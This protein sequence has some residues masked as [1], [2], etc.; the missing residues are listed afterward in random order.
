M[1]NLV[2]V[3]LQGILNI[4]TSVLDVLLYPINLLFAN[5]FPD[6]TDALFIFTGFLNNYVGSNL[7]WFFS[8]LPPNFRSLLILWFTFVIAYYSIYYT[9]R[10]SIRVF[11][12]IQKLKFW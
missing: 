7:A 3:L 9:Y 12:L 11:S 5:I 10:I 1:D 4:I 6:M 8:L 2:S